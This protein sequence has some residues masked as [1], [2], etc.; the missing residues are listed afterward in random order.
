MILLLEHYLFYFSYYIIFHFAALCYYLMYVTKKAYLLMLDTE[1]TLS[2]L[3]IPSLNSLSRISHAN[4]VGFSLLYAA[5]ASTTGGVATFGFEPP[6]T[7]AL[8]LPV[9]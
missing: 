9:S 4:I 1:G 2:W 6:M 8:K 5:I 3:Q 7:P